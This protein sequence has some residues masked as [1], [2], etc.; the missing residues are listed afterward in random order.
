MKKKV[1]FVINTMGRGG[2]ERCLINLFH[3]LDPDEVDI[4]LYS[5]IP[6]GELF[7]KVPD[8]VKI[9]NKNY[10]VESVMTR[11]A[12][13]HIFLEVLKAA[14]YRGNIFRYLGEMIR[15][16]AYQLKV[17]Q[18]DLK[19][20]VWKLLAMAAPAPRKEY[21]VAVAYIQGAATYYVADK[22]KAK[23]KVTFLH[24]EF[25]RSAYHPGL[26]H[27]YYLKFDRIYGVSRSILNNFSRL[28]PDCAEKTKVFYNILDEKDIRE[29]AKKPIDPVMQAD[30]FQRTSQGKNKTVIFLTAARLY[31]VKAYDIA[32]EALYQVRRAGYNAKWIVLGEGEERSALEQQI[33]KRKLEDSFLLLGAVDNPY[34]YI[35]NC[36]CYV[37]ATHYEGC[38]TAISEAVILGKPVLA[39]DCE[40]NRE[41]LER[42]RKSVV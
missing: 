33:R 39:S 22:V 41:Q 37:Q 27:P 40:G 30:L 13:F 26:N 19:K 18:P 23:K 2:A 5:I 20:P 12:R 8:Y 32:I 3:N 28:Y 11:E 36:D 10:Q 16:F 31:K 14:L 4:S 15:T 24:N 34:P 42:D 35:A 17:K 6:Y 38:C 9:L 25:E 1:L 21:D 7:D 29:K